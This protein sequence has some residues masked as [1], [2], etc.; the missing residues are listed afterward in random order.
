M[1]VTLQIKRG[2]RAQIDALAASQALSIGEPLLILDE[3]RMAVALDTGSYSGL[4]KQTEIGSGGTATALSALTDVNT[5]GL[6]SGSLLA[7]DATTTQWQPTFDPNN[8]RFDG[9]NF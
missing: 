6:A 7:Y 9:G 8:Q 4:A 3:G 1:S 5:T 2:T